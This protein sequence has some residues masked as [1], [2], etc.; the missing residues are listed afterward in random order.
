[1]AHLTFRIL[2]FVIPY[3]MISACSRTDT[4]IDSYPEITTSANSAPHPIDQW[5]AKNNEVIK[6]YNSGDFTKALTLGKDLLEYTKNSPAQNPDNLSQSYNLVG[7]TYLKLSDYRAAKYNFQKALDIIE[8]EYGEDHEL[9]GITINNL[10]GVLYK[11]GEYQS[12]EWFF[13]KALILKEKFNKGPSASSA[14]TLDNIGLSLMHQG[15]YE[16]A[17][18]YL[19]RSFD[20]RKDLFGPDS[21]AI[22]FSYNNIAALRRKTKEYSSAENLY[23]R[24]YALLYKHLGEHHPTTQKLVK[25]IMSFYKEIGKENDAI[26]LTNTLLE[27]ARSDESVFH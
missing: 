14:N 11:Q 23:K 10:G 6:H 22:A 25:N 27:Q 4:V 19:L 7:M 3:L 17:D 26:Q 16:A 2:V 8:H 20:V 12:S 18:T 15:N 9:A 24:A 5:H 21:T 1:M 13:R